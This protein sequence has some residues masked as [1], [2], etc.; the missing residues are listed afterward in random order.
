MTGSQHE[1]W[2]TADEVEYLDGLGA[3]CAGAHQES[4]RVSLDAL[5]SRRTLLT[6]YLEA[7]TARSDWGEVDAKEVRLHA[8]LLLCRE[9]G[10]GGS[11]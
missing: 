1:Q 11:F 10:I 4:A 3:H 2:T 5:P 8:L 6:R 9:A 7:Y